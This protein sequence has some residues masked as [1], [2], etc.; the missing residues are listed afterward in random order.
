MTVK[1]SVNQVTKGHNYPLLFFF[2]MFTCFEK[3]GER[4]REKEGEKNPSRLQTVSTE[5]R[6]GLEPKNHKIVT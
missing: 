3:G 6:V 2:L 4:E 5:P 1:R